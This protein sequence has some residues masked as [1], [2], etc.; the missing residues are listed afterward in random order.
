MNSHAIGLSS[1]FALAL[2]L[3]GPSSIRAQDASDDLST[4]LHQTWEAV[5]DYTIEQKNAL[6]ENSSELLAALDAQIDEAQEAASEASGAAKQEWDETIASLSAYR[7]EAA[8]RF[9]QLQDSSADAWED[10]KQRLAETLQNLQ[11][12]LDDDEGIE[13]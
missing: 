12:S 3:A 8:A 10:A 5:K 2:L 4:E 1:V 7:E 11:N 9:D 13:S 6:A